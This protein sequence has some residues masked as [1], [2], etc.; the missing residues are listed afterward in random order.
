MTGVYNLS[1]S[2]MAVLGGGL[3]FVAFLFTKNAKPIT[4]VAT[5]IIVLGSGLMCVMEPHINYAAYFFPSALLGISVGLQTAVVPLIVSVCTP[6]AMIGTAIMIS[7]SA[8]SFG[9][10]IGTVIFQQIFSS[11]IE[12]ILPEKVVPA[13]LKAGLPQTSLQALLQAYAAQSQE[14]IMQVPGFTPAVNSALTDAAAKSY[15]ASFRYIWYAL[16]AFSAACTILSLFLKSTTAMMTHEVAAE[17][18]HT[19]HHAPHLGHHGHREKTHNL[20]DEEV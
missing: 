17:V 1:F 3:I 14:M 5:G 11:K 15:A 12:D 20:E 2:V 19:H 9:G 10:S 4:V 6:N 7:N 16:L 13:V 8:R 18:E